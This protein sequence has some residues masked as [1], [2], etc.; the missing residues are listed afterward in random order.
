MNPLTALKFGAIAFA[1]L[2]VGW[3]LW[4]SGSVDRVHVIML[5][6]CGGVAAFA[7]YRSMRWLFVR[8][9][10]LPRHEHSAEPTTKH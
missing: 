8:R 5:S 2:W 6:I 7:W 10:A 3:M 1:I 4:W 9:G